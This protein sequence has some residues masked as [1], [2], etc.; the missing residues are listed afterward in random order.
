MRSRE[1]R[2]P[3]VPRPF[4]DEAFGS[5]FGRVAGIYR[6]TV[7][8]LASSAG[9]QLKLG[10]PEVGNWLAVGAPQGAALQRL[11]DLCRL[12][13]ALLEGLGSPA[14][15]SNRADGAWYCHTCLFLNPIDVTSPY[16]KTTWL[17]GHGLPCDAHGR[18]TEFVSAG[19]LAAHRHM[20]G[21]LKFISHRRKRRDY[22]LKHHSTNASMVR[23]Y[24]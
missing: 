10:Q 13:P 4:E 20:P 11:A 2:W 19:S 14:L 21:L 24:Q 18:R 22:L 16:W 6:M 1:E 9:L 3:V 5:W 8:E 15:V 17:K 12:T 7:D 23:G